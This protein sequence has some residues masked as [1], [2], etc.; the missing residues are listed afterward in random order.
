MGGGLGCFDS[1]P[2][3]LLPPVAGPFCLLLFDPDNVSSFGWPG[4]DCGFTR[5]EGAGRGRGGISENG[6]VEG[7]GG[8][9]KVGAGG[10]IPEVGSIGGMADVIFS[11]EEEREEEGEIPKPKPPM[12]LK[13][14]S[15]NNR[16]KFSLQKL[17]MQRK[18]SR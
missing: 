12:L 4:L 9:G 5:E 8:G 16:L 14:V 18:E 1:T 3:L 17:N 15:E 6:G 2:L 13:L 11:G 7:I 10:I